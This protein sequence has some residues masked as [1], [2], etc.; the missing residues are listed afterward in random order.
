MEKGRCFGVMELST[1]ENGW[2]TNPTEREV[3]LMGW[4]SPKGSSKTD[5]WSTTISPKRSA[6]ESVSFTWMDLPPKEWW[7]LL[8]ER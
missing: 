4:R 6:G 7:A 2:W 3:F 5:S 1:R 8:F